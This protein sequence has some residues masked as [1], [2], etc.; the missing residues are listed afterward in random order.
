MNLSRAPAWGGV[1]SS[2]AAA[3]AASLAARRESI[4]VA[5]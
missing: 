1:F 5:S 3:M 4:T 2:L